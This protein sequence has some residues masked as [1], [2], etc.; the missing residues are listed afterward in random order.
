MVSSRGEEEGR[1]TLLNSKWLR[2]LNSEV[3]Q[4]GE[5]ARRQ[6]DRGD[7]DLTERRRRGRSERDA[8]QLHAA[9]ETGDVRHG[10]RQLAG[11]RERRVH[12]GNDA[13][14]SILAA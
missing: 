2:N 11:G 8:Q 10:Q 14:R 6:L 4:I 1:M 3:E 9:A 7:L 13:A 5:I 12:G